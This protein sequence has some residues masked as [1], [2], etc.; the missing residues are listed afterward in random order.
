MLRAVSEIVTPVMSSSSM[1]T[2]VVVPTET[3]V[4]RAPKA[5]ATLSPSSSMS[6]PVALKVKDFS[7]SSLW[8]TRLSGTP[9]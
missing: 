3:L 8:N 9:L 6:S 5:S 4:G 7:V 1:L 2:V